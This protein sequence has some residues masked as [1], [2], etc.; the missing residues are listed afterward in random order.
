[1]NRALRIVAICLALLMLS[2][3]FTACGSANKNKEP[4]ETTNE[5]PATN[6]QENKSEAPKEKVKLTFWGGVPEESGPKELVDEYNQSQDE[7][8]VEYVRFVNDDAGNL[9]LDTTL[10]SGEGVDLFVTYTRDRLVTRAR[11]GSAVDM[12][13]LIAKYYPDY[14]K[15]VGPIADFTKVDGKIYGIENTIQAKCYTV[16]MKMFQENNIEIPK[17]WTIEEYREI[18]K[19]LTKGSGDDKVYGSFIFDG[20]WYKWLN[21]AYTKLGGNLLWKEDG[22]S[23]FDAPEIKQALQLY[24]DMSM[25][26]GSIPKLAET[27]TKKLSPQVMFLTEKAAMTDA[28]WIFRYIKDTNTYPHDFV[29]AF[30]PFP[31]MDKEGEYLCPGGNGDVISISSK[32]KYPEEAMKFL[33]WHQ[34]QGVLHMAKY[35]RIPASLSIP[36][37]KISSVMLEGAEHLF[38]KESFEEV[39]LGARF[40]GKYAVQLETRAAPELAKIVTEEGERALLGEINVDEAIANMKRRGDEALKN[41]K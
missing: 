31:S 3:L 21:P 37:E 14:E 27:K 41:A 15:D 39:F 24:Y 4:E 25:V 22:T 5:T 6:A 16:N 26:D 12:T 17:E 34:K 11:N 1:M 19:K 33:V 7:I 36:K 2:G 40:G 29:T 23:N 18:A 28:Q 13:D 9:K 30:V 10:M 20:D 8:I 35:G 32:S 38:D